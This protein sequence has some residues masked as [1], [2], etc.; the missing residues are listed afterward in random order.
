MLFA[1]TQDRTRGL[2]GHPGRS[3]IWLGWSERWYRHM[4]DGRGGVTAC[5]SLSLEE[6]LMTGE[7][8]K[9]HVRGPWAWRGD[10]Q[11]LGIQR[12]ELKGKDDNKGVWELGSS[13]VTCGL[14]KGARKRCG[15]ERWSK[16][17]LQGLGIVTDGETPMVSK[18]IQRKERALK[19]AADMGWQKGQTKDTVFSATW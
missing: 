14:L 15:W 17:A 13:I 12:Y 19:G 18:T 2:R 6:A 7:R 9:W 16:V 4:R 11:W 10:K 5:Q 8:L 1:A 3:T